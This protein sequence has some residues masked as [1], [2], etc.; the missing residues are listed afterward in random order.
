NIITLCNDKFIKV[1]NDIDMTKKLLKE[2]YVKYQREINDCVNPIYFEFKLEKE[3]ENFK[4]RIFLRD[5]IISG[6]NHIKDDLN[7]KIALAEQ[8]LFSMT[9]LIKYEQISELQGHTRPVYSILQLR[10]GLIATG[11]GD[12]T[13]IIWHKNT[14]YKV[15]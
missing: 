12:N 7:K 13:I 3:E 4:K 6:I 10:D 1:G 9:E 8:E 14:V 2:C 5:E 15:L 11:S